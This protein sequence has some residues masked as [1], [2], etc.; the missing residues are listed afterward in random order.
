[1][2]RGGERDAH[3]REEMIAAAE[4]GRIDLRVE[5]GSVQFGA[6]GAEKG[7]RHMSKWPPW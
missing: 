2:Q 4:E 3:V 1:M 5:E 7:F 6:R